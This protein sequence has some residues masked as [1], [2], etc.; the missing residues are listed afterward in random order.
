MRPYEALR[1]QRSLGVISPRRPATSCRS[2]CVLPYCGLKPTGYSERRFQPGKML[3]VRYAPV[4]VSG[5]RQLKSLTPSLWLYR[6]KAYS[7]R[8]SLALAFRLK[9]T[10]RLSSSGWPQR[11]TGLGTSSSGCAAW[12]A[13]ASGRWRVREVASEFED[14]ANRARLP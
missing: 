7:S 9:P 3:V 6:P 10:R 13:M 12:K 5:L 11:C 4:V 2:F 8:V 14:S 1:S